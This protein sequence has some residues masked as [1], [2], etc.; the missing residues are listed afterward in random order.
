MESG[1][2]IPSVIAAAIMLI[3]VAAM[4]G[5]VLFGFV[6]LVY[7]LGSIF[8][9]WLSQRGFFIRLRQRQQEWWNRHRIS[10]TWW[11]ESIAI[12]VIDPVFYGY[13]LVTLVQRLQAIQQ[14][15]VL[16]PQYNFWQLL[17]LDSRTH[18]QYYIA[19]AVIFLIWAFWKIHQHSHD[20]RF[21]ATTNTKLDKL[22]D[23]NK[24]LSETVKQNNENIGQLTE[25]IEKLV[26]EIKKDRETKHGK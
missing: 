15:A 8:Y 19:L 7:R 4:F 1:V 11:G 22:L 26:E 5:A 17:D 2:N 16:Y 9:K 23:S 24:T 6:S 13:A 10:A 21:E 18:M 20:V 14:Y 3:L 12:V 25:S